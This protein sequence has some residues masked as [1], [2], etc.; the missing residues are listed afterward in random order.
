M[1]LF[2]CV[3]F[4]LAAYLGIVLWNTLSGPP[5]N[6]GVTDRR[7]SPCPD[8]PNCVCSQD[9]SAS[10][11]IGPLS[12]SGSQSDALQHLTEILNK[13]PR[14]Q[15]ITQEGDYL[16]AEFRSLCFRFVDDVEF[17]F[18]SRQNVIHV[19]SASRVGYSDMGAN[20]KRMETIRQMFENSHD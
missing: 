9:T 11:E 1:I 8:S 2:W 5:E 4:L 10:H 6:L 7:L 17:L 3:P 18:D 20:R 15:I 19:R 16:H 14:C 12:Y 13:Q